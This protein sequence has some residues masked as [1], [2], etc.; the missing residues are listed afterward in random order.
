MVVDTFVGN[1]VVTQ[2]EDFY[3]RNVM[4]SFALD[5]LNVIPGHVNPHQFRVFFQAK[6]ILRKYFNII[7]R[8]DQ[9]LRISLQITFL[10]AKNSKKA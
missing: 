9:F 5:F 6:N 1:L 3:R 7:P 2:Y 8:E 4:E 10:S